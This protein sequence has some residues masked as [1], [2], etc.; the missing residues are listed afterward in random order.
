VKLE[1]TP[2]ASSPPSSSPSP[3]PLM[4]ERIEHFVQ[5]RTNG[6]VHD[7]TVNVFDDEVVLTGRTNTYYNKQLATHAVLAAFSGMVLTNDIE[8][9]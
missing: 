5:S 9:D 1:I 2:A 6:M 3:S 8:V 4:V 7:L